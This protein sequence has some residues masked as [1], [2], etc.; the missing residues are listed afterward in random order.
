MFLSLPC[1][2]HGS[3]LLSSPIPAWFSSTFL[4]RMSAGDQWRHSAVQED[5]SI[6]AGKFL[7]RDTRHNNVLISTPEADE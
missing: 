3:E 2:Q 7:I 5:A 1:I 6:H 4:A